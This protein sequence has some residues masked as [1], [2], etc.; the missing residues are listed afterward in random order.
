MQGETLLIRADA[1]VAMGTGHIMRCLALAQAWQ[2]AGGRC[3]FVIAEAPSALLERLRL[4]GM[5]V[6][7]IDVL[8]GSEDDGAQLCKLASKWSA[9]WA[10]VDGYHFDAQY[11]L[12]IKNAGFKLL[13]LDDHGHAGHYYADLVLNQNF[14]AKK[15][16][17]NNCEPYT[18][19]LLGS[20]HV[21]LRREFRAS[22]NWQRYIPATARKLLVTMGGSDP[23]NF[24]LAVLG[25][26]SKKRFCDLEVIIV[27]GTGNPHQHSLDAAAANVPDMFRIVKN[28]GNM[29][30]LMQSADLAIAIAGGTVW[31]L[32]CLGC[33]SL[34]YGRDDLQAQMNRALHAEGRLID[35]GHSDSSGLYQLVS[36]L[37]MLI[38]SAGKRAQISNLC[39]E[40]TDGRGV[41]RLLA[42][43]QLSSGGPIVVEN[44]SRSALTVP[45]SGSNLI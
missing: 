8:A 42:K 33:P 2:D 15:E 1:T 24:T 45:A 36:V 12:Q 17:Y 14:H 26:L 11:Q 31:E 34:V 18:E 6:E 19:L 3:C 7:Q 22:K 20:K 10:V 28:A 27:S 35:M 5:E 41:M 30:A 39:R 37:E 44:A 32:F 4:E 16:T 40:Y 23:D 13:F 9:A 43:M 29:A 25:A 38:P 21:L